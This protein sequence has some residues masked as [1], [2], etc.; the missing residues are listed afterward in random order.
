[1]YEFLKKIPLIFVLIV[2]PIIVFSQQTIK[3]HL[4]SISNVYNNSVGNE[5]SHDVT[6]NNI[7]L[8]E[9]KNL[10]LKRTET[11]TLFIKVICCEYDEK[12]PDF[13]KNSRIIDLNKI[14]L[15]SEY[16]FTIEVTVTENG[17]RYK[18]NKAKWKYSFKIK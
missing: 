2:T 15:S 11:D 1:M 10:N 14:D 9:Y 5:W 12:Y 16:S 8:S 7:P 13:G 6:V 17:G 3:V 4:D 18:G